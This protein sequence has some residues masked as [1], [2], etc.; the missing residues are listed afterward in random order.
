[1]AMQIGDPDATS[2]MTKAIYDAL[3]ALLEAGLDDPDEATLETLRAGWKNLAHG[4]AT[5]VVTHLQENLEVQDAGTEA[6]PVRDV[7][8]TAFGALTVTLDD[9]T[10]A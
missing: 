7:D 10:F 6:V 3:Q 8:G 1:M 2:G 4:I 9:L 5:G